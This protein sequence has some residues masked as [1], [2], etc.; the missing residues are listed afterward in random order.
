M[1]YCA[2]QVK[3]PA[4][5]PQHVYVAS[6]SWNGVAL[7]SLSIGYDQL[8]AGGT[9]QFEMTADPDEAGYQ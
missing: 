8:M 6:V 3:A 5:S 2:R 4:N 9:L 7:P 1:D